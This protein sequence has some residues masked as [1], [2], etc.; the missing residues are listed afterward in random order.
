[1]ITLST[2]HTTAPPSRYVQFGVFS[3]N[4][5][6]PTVA[7]SNGKVAAPSI[8][9]IDFMIRYC[10]M[11]VVFLLAC[12][13]GWGFVSV[14]EIPSMRWCSAPVHRKSVSCKRLQRP[15]FLRNTVR[16]GGNCVEKIERTPFGRC[17]RRLG[18]DASTRVGVPDSNRL[19]PLCKSNWESI[20]NVHAWQGRHTRLIDRRS[21]PHTIRGRRR[22]L[23]GI[24][25][26]ARQSVVTG[27]SRLVVFPES[28]MARL[29]SAPPASNSFLC[30][31]RS[32]VA[33]AVIL[34]VEPD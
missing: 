14:Y 18:A 25:R 30:Q 8:P 31:M 22:C 12:L 11:L 10:L 7:S 15:I 13:Q 17:N 9:A 6:D 28:P 29:S 26:H 33:G 21:T 27:G 23:D 5:A 4:I 19:G 3:G 34:K 20:V 32:E 16:I 1:M 2:P 24:L